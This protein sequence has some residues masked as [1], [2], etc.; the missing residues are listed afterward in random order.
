VLKVNVAGKMTPTESLAP[1]AV[2]IAWLT[3][4]PSKKTLACV[5]MDTPSMVWVGIEQGGF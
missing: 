4:L 2:V 5:W 1:L 3:H